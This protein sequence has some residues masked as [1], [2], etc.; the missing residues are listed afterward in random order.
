M[1]LAYDESLRRDIF[2]WYKA[3]VDQDA[4]ARRVAAALL[5][6]EDPDADTSDP[7][8][9]IRGVFREGL[10]P[11]MRSDAHVMRAFFRNFNLLTAPDALAND[12]EV[13]ASVLA[14]YNDRENRPPEPAMGPK[15]RAEL[16]ALLPA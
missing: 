14:A 12:A 9:F 13:G 6:G 16:V 5:A 2:P 7:R 10:V 11:A 3:G 15:L 4:E 1:A 8:T